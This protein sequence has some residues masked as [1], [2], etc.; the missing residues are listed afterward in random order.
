[1]LAFDGLDRGSAQSGISRYFADLDLD[2][3]TFFPKQKVTFFSIMFA[4]FTH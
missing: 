2:R 1:M 3:S 4:L